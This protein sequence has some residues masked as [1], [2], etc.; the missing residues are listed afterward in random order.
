VTGADDEFSDEPTDTE[1]AWRYYE[2]QIL[3]RLQEK[4]GDEAVVEPDQHL[5][6]RFSKVSRQIDIL[7][8]GSFAGLPE[9]LV[10]V[11]CKCWSRRVTVADVEQLIGMVEDVEASMGVLIT[12]VG[13]SKAAERRGGLSVQVEVVPFDELSEW[14]RRLPTVAYTV[15]TEWATLSYYEAGGFRTEQVPAEFAEA[16]LRRLEL[17][18]RRLGR[19]RTRAEATPGQRRR[20]SRKRSRPRRRS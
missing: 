5:P 1:P 3:D 2:D 8:R 16:V 4:A 19:T 18:A 13:A 14:T 7:V 20:S 12:N 15:G 17:R 9:M 11:D 6:G 10:V